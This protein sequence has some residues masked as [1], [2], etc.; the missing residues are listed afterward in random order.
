MSPTDDRVIQASIVG[1]RTIRFWYTAARFGGAR[2][3]FRRSISL[4]LRSTPPR[5]SPR[6]RYSASRPSPPDHAFLF[7]LGISGRDAE[8]MGDRG[9]NQIDRER[10]VSTPTSASWDYGYARIALRLRED[11][12]EYEQYEVG[13]LR[14]GLRDQQRRH[15]LKGQERL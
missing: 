13:R 10:S 1:V 5:R 2:L 7:S 6:W 12:M 14:D 8:P 9:R 4:P 3:A 15:D 11:A